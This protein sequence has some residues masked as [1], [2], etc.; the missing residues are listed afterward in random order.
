LR[1][2]T[3]DLI[4]TDTTDEGGLYRFENLPIGDYYVEFIKDEDLQFTFHIA[5][6]AF[7][8]DVDNVIS[9]GATS[10]FSLIGNQVLA[11]ID[12]GFFTLGSIGDFVWEDLNENGI[13]DL[14]EPGLAGVMI[15]LKNSQGEI[16]KTR[17]SDESG[18]YIFTELAPGSY[19]INL[20]IDSSFT[21]TIANQGDDELDSD[22]EL[23]A[24]VIT[25]PTIDILSGDEFLNIDFG[26]FEIPSI[27][28]GFTW[29]DANNDGQFQ[30]EESFIPN[31]TV[32][33]FASN[34]TQIAEAITN[35]GG[36]YSFDNVVAGDVYLQF[37]LPDG[38][39]FTIENQGDDQSDSDVTSEFITGS[40]AI[41][42]PLP[43]EVNLTN[44]AGYQ[45]LPKVGDFVWIDKNRNGLQDGGESGLNGVTVNLHQVNGTILESTITTTNLTT[46]T[47]GYYLFDTLSIGD[48]YISFEVID[49]LDF[50]PQVDLDLSFNSD[51]TGE[52]GEGTTANFSLIGNQ[53]NFII[54]GGYSLIK[55][56]ISGD[57]WVDSDLDG[58]Q[59]PDD[60]FVEGLLITLYSDA[61]IEISSVLS[62]SIGQY[63]FGDLDAG[64][65]YVVF[66]TTERY[67][68]TL[69]LQGSDFALDSDIDDSQVPGSTGIIMLENG[70]A[71]D[72]IDAGL[73]DGVV[74][75]EGFTW[76]DDDNNGTKETEEL[77]LEN[78][79]VKLYA[80]D[81]QLI[82]S[83]MVDEMGNYEFPEVLPGEY[84]LVFDNQDET[85]FN[86]I[87]NQGTD[88][89][90]DDITNDIIS[91][92]TDTISISYFNG[93]LPISG[94]Y[95]QL[96]SLG[97]MAFI[98]V[99]ENGINDQEPGLDRVT[100]NLLT[101]DGTIIQSAMTSQ[102]GGI[103]S[104]YYFM[105]DIVPGEYQL[106]F[107]R[108]L[109]YQFIDANV[110]MNDSIDSDV[111][112][113]EANF[114]ITDTFLLTSGVSNTNFDA[115]FVF[116][117]PEEASITGKVW[118]DENVNG[119]FEADEILRSSIV[120]EL[121][122]NSG[123]VIDTETTDSDG[124]YTF[125]MLQE[126]FYAL[127]VTLVGNETA[128]IPNLGMD[129]EIDSDFFIT[130]LDLETNQFFLENLEDKD[131]VDLGIVDKITI[132]NFI[133]EDENN[134]GTQE[135]TESGL[136]NISVTITDISTSLS[137]TIVT[138]ENGA[139][140]F[141]DFPA[142][143]YQICAEIPDGFFIG[144]KDTG[145]EQLDSDANPDGCTDFMVY[146]SGI[147]NNIDIAFTKSASINGIVFTD[148]NGNG[149][150]NT[151]EPGIGN[152]PVFLY[153]VAGIK[154]DS[155]T[156][157][158][159]G[160]TKG[161]YSFTN[162]QVGD[163]YV[164][165]DIPEEYILS[166]GNSGPD[167]IDSDISNAFGIGSTNVIT[168]ES[169][170]NLQNTDGGA[171][172]PASIRGRVWEDINKNGLQDPGEPDVE[173]IEVV[174]FFSFGIAFDTAYTNAQGIYEFTDLK[175][176]LYFVQFMIPQQFTVT[177]ESIG[178]D[179]TIDSDADETGKT[180][181]I[182]LTHGVDLEHLDCG[183][184][185]SMASLRSVV[186][187]DLNG[188]GMRQSVEA[189]IPDIRVS[190]YNDAGEIVAS[191]TS[192]SL[193]LYAFQEI[194]VGDYK[195]FVD[196]GNTDYAFTSIDMSSDDLLDSDIHENG[197]S[198]MF[199]SAGVLS[200][201]NVD[202]GLFEMGSIGGV[203]WFDED[204]NGIYDLD[205]TPLSN[206][207]VSLYNELDEMVSE[208]TTEVIGDENITF[209]N[210]SPGL[211][212][213]EYKFNENL[214]ATLESG[215]I[216][217][218]NNS[219]II[220]QQGIYS[221][222]T[223]TV[224][225]SNI[226]THID[227]GFFTKT[228]LL[229]NS[230]LSIAEIGNGNKEPEINKTDRSNN[231]QVQN[232]ELH[233]SVHPNPATNYIRIEVANKENAIVKVLNAEK[234]IVLSASATQMEQIDLQ[235]LHPGI[236]YVV[237]EQNGRAATKKLIKVH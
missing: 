200:M 148:V 154:I 32:L 15:A 60:E 5:D 186:W 195:V 67:K 40:T 18:Y 115:G 230:E 59:N 100:V 205:E 171:Y 192:N 164:V 68:S 150:N 135:G 16:I 145:I 203:A 234:K 89:I 127:R 140:Q 177:M 142:G 22:S 48:Y 235:H 198:D 37:E 2:A 107:I 124:E 88:E 79:E 8:S 106:E 109:F 182:A 174:I 38:H 147:N 34:G 191:T 66:D 133:W 41:I 93:L 123:S 190:L 152:V 14:D 108:P 120:V 146:D 43:G 23:V 155:T 17:E 10:T 180:P 129:D 46:G 218:D 63:A 159:L 117:T 166:D 212:R 27:I 125:D 229:P 21:P 236:Y 187:E 75:I 113:V 219:D 112:F 105:E 153:T 172:L 111:V 136:A 83:M 9:V 4:S 13:Q 199:A 118:D 149:I 176:G 209:T 50:A 6:I 217:I 45:A 141:I 11:G 3:G 156:T 94:G 61:N 211:Y 138:D 1:V 51:I 92:S 58:I 222:P 30:I 74:S 197:E 224:E 44:A 122:D 104:G 110:G 204:Q 232:K 25:S 76:I 98:D 84:Y 28:G 181:L 70:I 162:I 157:E 193:G 56:E 139:Y 225:S 64:S 29:L 169:G 194:P 81:G 178:M 57:V 231:T 237:L 228:I 189:R 97:D 101:L 210:L 87:A 126:G 167:D 78:I 73:I 188:D 208:L 130:E 47:D 184:F 35:A 223:F 201:P 19:T 39:I 114:G 144:K 91:G 33:L 24:G 220:H 96:A 226:V 151:G 42:T 62:D 165:F 85:F 121:L 161:V 72:N 206:V 128:T 207:R 183:I 103:D 80:L 196:I 82:D 52:N 116:R 53:C 170:E 86:V 214:E 90:D 95:Y 227:A 160:D 168:L 163:Y 143:N 7:N 216:A 233:F 158:S 213:M 36:L 26:F 202:V 175:Q 31:V 134:N 131:F 99:N 173:G 179:D 12:A 55:S 119:T 185:M 102:G 132:G 69:S 54:D 49:T 65:Y 221:S 71:K 77:A 215:E 137:D 20:I